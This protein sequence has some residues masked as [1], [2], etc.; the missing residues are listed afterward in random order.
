VRALQNLENAVKSSLR[1]TPFF[2]AV[3]RIYQRRVR[4]AGL[5]DAALIDVTDGCNLRCPFCYNDWGERRGAV[6][7]SEEHF[8]KVIEAMP[9]V[10][11]AGV[12][13]SCSFEP[14]LHPRFLALLRSIPR[15]LRAKGFFSTN[16]AARLPGDVFEGLAS[17]PLHHI[18]ISLESLSRDTYELCRKGASFPRFLENLGRLSEAISRAPDGPALHFITMACRL[19]HREIP[20]L[21]ERCRRELGAAY[22]EIRPFTRTPANEAWVGEHGIG[23]PEWEEL[24]EALEGLGL[25]HWN[26]LPPPPDDEPVHYMELPETRFLRIEAGGKLQLGQNH[27]LEPELSVHL[28]EIGHMQ[29]FLKDWIRRRDSQ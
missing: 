25:R 10:R 14:F 13:I 9:L 18:N 24:R 23:R 21:V 26:L 1:R 8:R 7:M 29:A 16:L 11:D 2:G 22:H 3:K 28:D 27:A 15:R 4:A 5:F 19:N 17:A 20:G 6:S 12:A